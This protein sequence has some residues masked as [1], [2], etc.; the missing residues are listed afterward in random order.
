MASLATER[1]LAWL[2]AEHRITET[3]QQACRDI[4][5]AYHPGTV[6]TVPNHGDWQP[7]NWLMHEGELRV[8]D[9][10]RF[11]WR[12]AETDLVRLTTQ[13]WQGRPDPVTTRRTMLEYDYGLIRL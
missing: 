2:E 4:L 13:Q 12:A 3:V 9:F 8:I 1:A 6:S 11:A 10:G 7:Q 5:L